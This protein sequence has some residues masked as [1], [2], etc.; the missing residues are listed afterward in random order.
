VIDGRWSCQVW[1]GQFLGYVCNH[2]LTQRLSRFVF[3]QVIFDIELLFY[4]EKKYMG[5][6]ILFSQHSDDLALELTERNET[7]HMYL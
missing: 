2:L 4:T 3:S 6:Q 7:K 1:H 5:E